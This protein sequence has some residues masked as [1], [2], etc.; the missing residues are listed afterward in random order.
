MLSL[1][2][3]LAAGAS[4]VALLGGILALAQAIVTRR[5]DRRSRDTELLRWGEDVIST[6][7]TLEVI[8]GPGWDEA[9][10]S[11]RDLMDKMISASA[12]VDRGRLFFADRRGRQIGLLDSSAAGGS[13]RP[14]LLDEVL[15]TY[16][17]ARH[18]VV[19]GFDEAQVIRQGLWESRVRFVGALQSQMGSSMKRIDHLP[20]GDGGHAGRDHARGR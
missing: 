8:A 19:H 11:R 20:H 18:L 17:A 5:S 7:A 4:V 6:M 14:V 16:Y 2:P 13:H 10:F 1:A 12:L 9:V 3:Y 15:K